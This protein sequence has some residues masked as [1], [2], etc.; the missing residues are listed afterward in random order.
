MTFKTGDKKSKGTTV[1]TSSKP[2]T[3]KT[4]P[5]SCQS[6]D[7]IPEE[8]PEDESDPIAEL[9]VSD[10]EA[11]ELCSI[12]AEGETDIDLKSEDSEAEP[13]SW[14]KTKYDPE[15]YFREIVPKVL[16]NGYIEEVT[17][18]STMGASVTIQVE[19][20]KYNALVDTGATRSCM[21][22]QFYE[23]CM[24]SGMRNICQVSVV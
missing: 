10:T 19:R 6:L 20:T 17:I 5:D 22:K 21:S 1:P 14:L 23:K 24:L 12:L 16:E 4:K 15:N 9:E 7:I 2:K 3:A 8:E 18:G 13:E 11:E